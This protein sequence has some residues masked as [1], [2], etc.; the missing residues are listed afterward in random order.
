VNLIARLPSENLNQ[1]YDW[2][3][4]KIGARKQEAI[5]QT[6]DFITSLLAN[7]MRHQILPFQDTLALALNFNIKLN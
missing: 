6:F 3:A 1:R 7:Q 2:L 5:Q 4:K